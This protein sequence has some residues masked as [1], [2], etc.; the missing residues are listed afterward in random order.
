[1]GS[2]GRCSSGWEESLRQIK[3]DFLIRRLLHCMVVTE[4][5]RCG[6]VY[7]WVSARQCDVK[8]L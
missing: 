1:M 2:P 3:H 4:P 5:L 7:E 8:E 6:G